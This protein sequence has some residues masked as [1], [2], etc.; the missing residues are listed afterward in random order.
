MGCKGVLITWARYPDGWLYRVTDEALI[1]E[2]MVWPNFFLMNVFFALKRSKL[3]IIIFLMVAEKDNIMPPT[4][5]LHLLS[6]KTTCQGLLGSDN[7]RDK[8]FFLM[9]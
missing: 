7:N 2:T 4:I 5:Q 6:L 3:F 9:C 8:T 1:A